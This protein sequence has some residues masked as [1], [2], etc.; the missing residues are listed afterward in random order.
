MKPHIVTEDMRL[1]A[2]DG[3]ELEG[4]LYLPRD[5]VVSRLVVQVNG[6]GPQTCNT[7]RDRGDGTTYSFCGFFGEELAG[8]GLGFFC[9]STRGCT[10]GDQGPLYCRVDR[11]V[12]RSYTPQTC[13]ADLEDWTALLQAHPRCVGAELLLL[14][15]SEGTMIAPAVAAGGAVPLAG[16]LLAGYANGTME[17]ALDWQQRGLGL[18]TMLCQYFDADGDGSISREEFETGPGAV[19]EALEATFSGLDLDGD[20]R[21][22]PADL[23]AVYA[24]SRAEIFRAIEAGDDEWLW[25]HYPVPLTTNWFRGHR[26]FPPTGRPCPVW[27]CPSISSRG[28]G[29]PTPLRRTPWPSRRPSGGWGRTT[30]P[31]TSTLTQDTPWALSSIWPPGNCPPPS[32]ISLS[33]ARGWD[34]RTGA[35]ER[36]SPAPA[37]FRTPGPGGGA[38]G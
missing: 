14:G 8:R 29:T 19:R 30:S 32:P 23:E 12:Y 10:D 13:V 24:G 34:D 36:A 37:F 6:S 4:K 28:G 25:E 35:G 31:S 9:Y 11:A 21:I 22:T 2:R 33:C 1:R 17:E 3:Q 7:F 16:L 15:W 5:G 20:G 38:R 18:Y 26:R 27:T